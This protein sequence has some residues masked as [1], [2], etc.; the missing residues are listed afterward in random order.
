MTRRSLFKAAAAAFAGSL[1][2]KLPLAG[3]LPD[4]PGDFP[5]ARKSWIAEDWYLENTPD[6]EIRIKT[7]KTKNGSQRN[8]I[9]FHSVRTSETEEARF[10]L[11][12]LTSDPQNER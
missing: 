2:A 3:A 1:L 4:V 12:E 5:P 11:I 10:K 8:L 7:P 9:V 6:G